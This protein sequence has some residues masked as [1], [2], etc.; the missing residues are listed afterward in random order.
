[1]KAAKWMVMTCCWCVAASMIA[2]TTV[3]AQEQQQERRIL[4]YRN[5]MDPNITSPVPAKDNMGMDYVPV[6]ADDEQQA[7]AGT[8]VRI[9]PAVVQNLGVRTAPVSRGTLGRRIDAVGTVAYD[10]DL[11]AH[12]HTRS[13]GW[14]ESLSVHSVGARVEAG[15]VLFELYSP[16]LASAQDEL[17]QAL[18]LGD[19]ELIE[20][21]RERLR[22]LGIDAEQVRA[23]ERSRQATSRIP[24]RAPQSGV[25]T[26]LNVRHGMF[27][28]P[29]MEAMALTDTSSVWVLVDVPERQAAWVAAEQQAEVRLPA[30]PGEMF[31]S[32]V[33]FVYPSLDLQTR[34]LR[35]R[36]RFDNPGDR[37]KPGMYA[38]VQIFAGPQDAVLSVPRQALIRSGRTDRVIVAEGAGRFRAVDVVAGMESGDEVEIREGLKEGEQ[39]VVTGQFLIDSE[40]SIKA[41]AMRIQSE[42]PKNDAPAASSEPAKQDVRGEGRVTAVMAEHRMLTL[43]HAPIEALGWPAMTMDFNVSPKVELAGIK[44]GDKIRFVL[45]KD[46]AGNYRIGGIHEVE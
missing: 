19:A 4:F 6:Y 24:V 30:A 1:M 46:G 28:K 20:A 3:V 33:E 15:D 43:D 11:I 31:K 7:G 8:T 29:D 9:D 45:E 32:E 36:L 5:P 35:A 25:V 38:N 13:E 21:S 17:L 27:V 16:V 44:V 12:I 42:A 10:E 26:L 18:R 40:A 22:L 34:T 37:I 2:P 39:V 41:S 23:L 14:V